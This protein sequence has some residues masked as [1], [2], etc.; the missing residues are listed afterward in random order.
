MHSNMVT[1]Y[2]EGL[3]A[4]SMGEAWAESPGYPGV[5]RFA[6]GAAKTGMHSNMVHVTKYN[7]QMNILEEAGQICPCGGSC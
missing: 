1:S 5:H 7:C 2:N 3:T 6:A 4:V